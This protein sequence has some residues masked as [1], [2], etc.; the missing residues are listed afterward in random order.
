MVQVK[1]E[2]P[3]KQVLKFGQSLW[4]DGLIAPKDFECLIREDGIRGATTNPT[5]FEKALSSHEYDAHIRKALALGGTAEGIYRDLAVRAVQEVA[6]VFLPVYRQTGGGDGYVSIEVSPL[7]AYQTEAT[8]C[9]ARQ[10]HR[11]VGRQNIMIKVPATREGVPAV[12]RLI[13]EGINVNVTLIFSVERYREVMDAYLGG[14]QERAKAGGQVRNVASVASFFVSRVDTAVDGLLQKKIENGTGPSLKKWLGKAA[15]ANSK[16][17]YKEF[18]SV[19][20]KER[21]KVLEAKGARRQ[22]P[23]W[24]STGTKNPEYGDVFYVE[25]LIGP[26]SVDTMPAATMDAYRDHGHPASRIREGADE[27]VKVFKMLAQE[28]VLM[29]DVTRQ[30]EEAGVKSFSDSYQKI[31]KDVEAKR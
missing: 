17:A 31:L 5:I 21:F 16:L 9:E 13:A 24:A 2:N 20:S 12:R 27:A 23:L 4:Y 26:E 22:R 10:L 7:L 15:I 6:D 29:A 28:G 18:E 19:F 25:A 8:L 11:L 3:L 1:T 30:L 14:L